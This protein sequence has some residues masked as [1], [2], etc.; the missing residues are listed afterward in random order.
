[1]EYLDFGLVDYLPVWTAMQARSQLPPQPD[2]LWWV[3][4]PPLYTL[5]V[6]AKE[7]DFLSDNGIPRLRVDRG[8]QVTYHGPGQ[9]VIYPLLYLPRRQLNVQQLVFLLEQAV[10]DW[11]A[12]QQIA[13]FR[14]SGA[15]GVY[16]QRG[17]IASVG[18]RVRRGGFSYHGL[19]V[20]VDMDLTPF[21]A[22]RPCGREQP[23]TQWRDLA[24]MWSQHHAKAQLLC[25]LSQGLLGSGRAF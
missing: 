20:N 3:E 11:L 1:V 12:A 24:P 10:I 25:F 16:T 5:G 18:L 4:H 9:W 15:P 23:I 17:K 14:Q 19:S 7:A 6:S 2:A 13:A 8:G 22:I 21:A